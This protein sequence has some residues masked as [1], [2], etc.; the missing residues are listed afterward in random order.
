MSGDH[1][2]KPLVHGAANEKD[3]SFSPDG[4]WLAYLSDESGSHQLYVIPYPGPGGKW[5]LTSNG[6]PGLPLGLRP[7]DL[8]QAANGK[9]YAIDLVTGRTAASRSARRACWLADLPTRAP[10]PTPAHSSAVPDRGPGRVAN[11]KP[12]ITLVTNWVRELSA[13]NSGLAQ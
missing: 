8:Q 3:G 2:L 12:P 6:M 5:Q 1:Q 13:G 4:K 11:Q 7:R 10:P 9:L